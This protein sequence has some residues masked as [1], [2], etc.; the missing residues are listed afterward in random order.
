MHSVNEVKNSFPA[1]KFQEFRLET[2]EKA[3][4]DLENFNIQHT[5]MLQTNRQNMLTIAR[6]AKTYI[7][8]YDKTCKNT[9]L[10]S[11]KKMVLFYLYNINICI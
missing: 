1:N 10:E 11:K 9:W 5:A 2:E 8:D 3:R 7:L 6:E 4:K